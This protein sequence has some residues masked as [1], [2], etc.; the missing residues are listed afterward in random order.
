MIATLL[1]IAFIGA[2]RAS[3]MLERSYDWWLILWG[4]IPLSVAIMYYLVR[5]RRVG[6]R[7]LLILVSVFFTLAVILGYLPFIMLL[8]TGIC[9]A[10][11]GLLLYYRVIVEFRRR[12][13]A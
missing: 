2:L 9:T 5:V 11:V 3:I 4:L 1:L 7:E 8:V 12:K 6:F 10:G 13:Y